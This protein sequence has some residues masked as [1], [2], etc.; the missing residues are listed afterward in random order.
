MKI[1]LC[2]LT[3]FFSTNLCAQQNKFIGIWE[4]KINVG[5]N[6][7]IAF[8]FSQDS[9]GN[10]ITTMDSPDQS[11]FGLPTDYTYISNDSVFTGIKKYQVSFTGKLTSDSTIS[12]AFKQTASVPLQLKKVVKVNVATRPQTPVEPFPYNSEDVSYNSGKSVQVAGTLTYP[13]IDPNINYIKAPVYPAVLLITGSGPQNRNEEIMGHKPFAVIADFLTKKGFIVL[14]VD[15]RGTGK[16]TGDYS[17]ATSGDFADDVIAGVNFLK[18][19]KMLILQGWGYW[20]T[21]K[22]E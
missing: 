19:E 9:A 14:R 7:R 11:A 10:F 4:G 21:V 12:G 1:K 6:L 8:H 15:D 18:K 13:K 2:L 20:A 22:G 17:K 16:S 3:I 5:V